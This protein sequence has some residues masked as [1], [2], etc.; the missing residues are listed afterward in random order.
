MK[1]R[2]YLL[3]EV[4]IYLA[5]SAV[6]LS[7]LT[8]LFIPYLNEYR[9]QEDSVFDLNYL[10][11]AHIYIHKRINE[12]K[13][14]EVI[15]D[16]DSIYL[17][18]D[19]GTNQIDVIKEQKGSLVVEYYKYNGKVNTNS[20]LKQVEAFNVIEKGNLFYV[21]IKQNNQEERIFC[22]EKK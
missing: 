1:K 14:K 9:Q 6:F 5:I 3:I 20:L 17:Y 10:L 8:S 13:I 4:V 18:M 21:I 22:Y 19:N 16:N 2:G 11:S 12:P 7:T 15:C